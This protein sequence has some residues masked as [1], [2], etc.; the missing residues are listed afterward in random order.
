MST[1]STALS[2]SSMREG[3]ICDESAATNAKADLIV[4]GA[5]PYHDSCVNV[6]SRHQLRNCGH[7]QRAFASQHKDRRY[8][9]IVEDTI[10]PEFDYWYFAIQDQQ[11]EVQAIQPFF[12]LDQDILAGVHPYFRRF[13]QAIRLQ[14][15]RF[16]FM[17]TMMVGCV[18]GEA[19]LDEGDGSARAAIARS[20]AGAIVKHAR[21]LGARLIVLK[22]FPDQY[23]DVLSCFVRLGFTRIPS[24]PMTRL[25][26]AYVSFDDYM[27]SA[28][29]SATRR[30]LRKK[31]KATELDPPIELSV[32]HDVTPIINEIYPLYLQVYE[33]SKLHFEKLTKEY[34]CR[35]G[36]TMADKVRFFVWR[37]DAKVVAFGVCMVH[38][39]T[40]FAEYLGLDYSVALQLHLYHYV[41]RD[42]VRW[43]IANGYTWFQSS[44]LNY[45]PKLHLRHRLKPIDLYVRHASAFI[46]VLMRV[47]LP[48]LEPTRHD[49]TLKKFPNYLDLWGSDSVARTSRNGAARSNSIASTDIRKGWGASHNKRSELHDA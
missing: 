38:G 34:F 41:F 25:N 22:E 42:L 28:L 8:Y 23:R 7:W 10:H 30:K 40:M 31:F 20:L 12:I 36:T 44:G 1:P 46:N 16:M 35:L 6:V 33:R 39:D 9:E 5:P 32:I 29:N 21:A 18:A 13:A 11:G 24:M 14:W 15:P 4:V 37:R 45:D 3:E 26:I 19:H 47:A 48:L 17:K 43:A 2:Q 27:Q 49:V